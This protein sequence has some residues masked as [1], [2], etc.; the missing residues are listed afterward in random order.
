M[1][2]LLPIINQSFAKHKIRNMQLDPN[3]F[4]NA[5][6]WF[7]PV[8]YQGNVEDAKSNM[9][10]DLLEK[11]FAD[12]IQERDNGGLVDPAFNGFYTS[13][14]NEVLLYR[15]FEEL[16]KIARKYKLI[17]MVL[18]N[19]TPLSPNKTD[20][21]IE[22]K[23]VISGVCLNVPCFEAELWAKRVNLSANMF[24]RLIQ[25]IRYFID[26]HPMRLSIQVNGWDGKNTWLE[27]G[28]D[29]P[30]DLQDDENEKQTNLAKQLFP[31]ANV[32]QMPHL[33]DRAGSI[34]TVITNKHAIDKYHHGKQVVGCMN[35]AE[36]GGR[37]VGW[38]HVN[39]VGECFLCCND[40]EME[41]KFG[42]FKTQS[43]RDF[44]GKE[45]HINTIINSYQ[46]MCVNCASAQFA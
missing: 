34:A 18:S 28:Q 19:G 1:I 4:C 5:G 26:H 14:Y 20:L 9:P 6:C 13:H 7:C 40:V 23:D 24:P 25:N 2:D 42:D 38:I 15:H 16:L 22:Y 46:G 36:S 37:P 44:W 29:F 8:R 10:V 45:D 12:I 27:K 21:L 3:G 32:F 31:E 30:E 17:F 41:M 35:S 43:L 11:I 33:V 39:S